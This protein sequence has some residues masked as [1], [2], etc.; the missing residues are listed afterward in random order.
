MERRC[1]HGGSL[2]CP[3]GTPCKFAPVCKFVGFW[4]PS[5][6]ASKGEFRL[7]TKADIPEMLQNRLVRYGFEKISDREFVLYPATEEEQNSF[8]GKCPHKKES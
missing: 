7:T 2:G 4:V 5:Q 8:D 6:M 1:P 3:E